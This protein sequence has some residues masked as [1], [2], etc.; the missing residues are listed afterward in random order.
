MSSSRFR[1]VLSCLALSAAVFISGCGGEKLIPVSGKVTFADGKPLTSGSV[2]FKP[3]KAK[4]NT[5][6]GEAIGEINSSGEYTLQSRG[7]PGAP[8]GAYKVIV[9]STGPTTPDNTKVSTQSL[10]PQKYLT[11][12]T[13]PLEKTVADK[14]P[15]GTYD[16]QLLP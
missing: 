5:F 8:A 15:A 12:E 1:L 16:L 7:K 9:T 6:S 10:V 13:T 3:D 11:A 14:A 2:M 4:G